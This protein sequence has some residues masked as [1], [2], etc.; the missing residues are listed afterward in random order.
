VSLEH[1]E[2]TFSGNRRANS[3]TICTGGPDIRSSKG[4]VRLALDR[5]GEEIV[6]TCKPPVSGTAEKI[7]ILLRRAF[8]F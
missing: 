8:S 5:N 7:F 3:P 4:I 1:P 6:V 2:F